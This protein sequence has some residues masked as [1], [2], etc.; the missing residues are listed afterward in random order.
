MKNIKAQLTRIPWPVPVLLGPAFVVHWFGAPATAALRYDR[1]AI[2]A[3]ELWRLVTGH[4]VHLGALHLALNAVATLV[5]LIGFVAPRQPS[6]PR[7]FIAL[8]GLTLGVSA[9]LLFISSEVEWYVGLS[10]VLHGLAVFVAAWYLEKPFKWVLLAGLLVKLVW[11][12]V[13][14]AG[15]VLA[16][17]LG[18][19][20]IVDAH[21][22]GGITACLLLGVFAAW[23][24]LASPERGRE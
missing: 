10:G 22:Y 9:G 3:G 14:G 24:R 7:M 2:F 13:K 5:I 4:F 11:E 12:Q 15:S 17:E 18:G 21:L 1:E 6:F 16:L 19:D 8:L 23:S 20:V